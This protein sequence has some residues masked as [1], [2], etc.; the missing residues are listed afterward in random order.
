M[1]K[2]KIR[3]HLFAERVNGK[4]MLS[5]LDLER[6]KKDV[7]DERNF[8]YGQLGGLFG[9]YERKHD[10]WI[11]PTLSTK[12]QHQNTCTQ[13]SA[14]LQ[15]EPDEGVVLSEQSLTCAANAGGAIS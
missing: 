8:K 4:K 10:L 15:A 3:D 11:I 6:H 7:Q 9:G 13:E 1:I 5:G 2:Q 12:L 14:T